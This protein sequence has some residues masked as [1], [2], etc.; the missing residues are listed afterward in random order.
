MYIQMHIF[1]SWEYK[2]CI[3]LHVC[4]CI[5]IYIYT[6]VYIVEKEY[7]HLY[8]CVIEHGYVCNDFECTLCICLCLTNMCTHIY[9]CIC[10]DLCRHCTVSTRKCI[11]IYMCMYICGYS[12]ISYMHVNIHLS[13]YLCICTNKYGYICN[14]S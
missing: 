1:M 6:Y 14:I 8:I 9:I 5:Y 7:M 4:T 10:F 2:C 11:Y 3:C 13:K 12:P